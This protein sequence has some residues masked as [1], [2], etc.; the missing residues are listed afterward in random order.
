[1]LLS[2]L[3]NNFQNIDKKPKESPFILENESSIQLFV[4]PAINPPTH[5]SF[6]TLSKQVTGFLVCVLDTPYSSLMLPLVGWSWIK[7]ITSLSLS[8]LICKMLSLPW[9][10][11]G[12]YHSTSNVSNHYLWVLQHAP[13][14]R[15]GQELSGKKG[16]SLDYFKT[17][18]GTCT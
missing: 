2:T 7:D 18:W 13:A 11:S 17:L 14:H 12:A 5:Q 15:G 6:H 8:F 10:I 16:M 9:R 4:Y 1:M 3:L